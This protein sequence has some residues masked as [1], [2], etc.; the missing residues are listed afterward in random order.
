[1][2][3]ENHPDPGSTTA[4][5]AASCSTQHERKNCSNLNLETWLSFCS[6]AVNETSW[7]VHVTGSKDPYRSLPI[8]TF[9]TTKQPSSRFQ[10]SKRF[11]KVNISRN[12]VASS[13]LQQPAVGWWRWRHQPSIPGMQCGDCTFQFSPL[14]WL[15]GPGP[16]SAEQAFDFYA[17]FKGRAMM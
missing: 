15:L 12:S 5:T 10:C 13:P 8:I 11:W 3:N 1:M 7:R 14:H 4:G 9:C 6:K 2:W 16:G 17:A